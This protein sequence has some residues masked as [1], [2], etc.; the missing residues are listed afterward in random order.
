LPELD[1]LN[2]CTHGGRG[3]GGTTKESTESLAAPLHFSDSTWAAQRLNQRVTLKCKHGFKSFTPGPLPLEGLILHS[4]QKGKRKKKKRESHT[5][6]NQEFRRLI[7]NCFS[8]AKRVSFDSG[9][10]IN[11][12]HD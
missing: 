3:Q 6:K 7:K 4:Q 1:S 11:L 12:L 2:K 5:N 8:L 9:L 10:K